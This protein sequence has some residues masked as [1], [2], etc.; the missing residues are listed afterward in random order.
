MTR[1]PTWLSLTAL[2]STAI[3]AV[4]MSAPGL[5]ASPAPAVTPYPN[6]VAKPAN[7]PTEGMTSYPDYGGDVTCATADK[8]VGSFN[9]L[10]YKG[11]LKKIEAPD[12]KTVVFSFCNPDVA[13][14]SQIAFDS[15]AIDDAGYLIKWAADPD[16]TILV[17]PNGTGPYQRTL[18]DRG[19]RLDLEPNP[20]YWG[21]PPS[22]R[23]SS[24]SGA[25]SPPRA[26]SRSSPASWTASTIPARTTC[27]RS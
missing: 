6:P 26:W 7:P 1:R 16:H 13:F 3:L 2:G 27:L 12:N 9:G 8:P 14:L 23:T 10:P 20:N 15:L 22:A 25:A 17:K 18:W 24:S 4:S 5:A 21:A 19:Y 11:N